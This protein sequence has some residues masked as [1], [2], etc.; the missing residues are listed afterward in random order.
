MTGVLGSG[1]YS[2]RLYLRTARLV[3]YELRVKL[4]SELVLLSEATE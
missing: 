2:F 1:P 3:L 4:L